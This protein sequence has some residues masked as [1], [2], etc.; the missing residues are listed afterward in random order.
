M[1]KLTVVAVDNTIIL[2]GEPLVFPF[3]ISSD[4]HAIQWDG[5]KN[6]GEIEY[7]DVTRGNEAITDSAAIQIFID[8]HIAEKER[9]QVE[10]VAEESKIANVRWSKRQD[11]IEEGLKRC[12]AKSPGMGNTPFLD[13]LVLIWPALNTGSAPAGLADCVAIAEYM[14]TKIVS[15][16][17]MSRSQLNAYSPKADTNFPN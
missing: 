4:I 7:K 16:D 11:V 13:F 10:I 9:L 6:R 5:A 8:A 15:I 1:N 3:A 2:D 14:T 12:E 17:T